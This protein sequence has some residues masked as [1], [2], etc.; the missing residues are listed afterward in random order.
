M[1]DCSSNGFWRAA[2]AACVEVEVIVIEG[3][4]QSDWYVVGRD[5]ESAESAAG[6]LCRRR[7]DR[8][9]VDACV[10]KDLSRPSVSRFVL[11][12]SGGS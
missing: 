7:A 3:Y 2:S 11:V 6:C 10:A 1:A 12:L 5:Q 9:V 4:V 8:D